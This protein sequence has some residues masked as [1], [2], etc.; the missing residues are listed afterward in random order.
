MKWIALPHSFCDADK[1]VVWIQVISHD[2]KGNMICVGIEFM[3]VY[4]HILIDYISFAYCCICCATFA[5]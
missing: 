2:M 1:K 4:I 3:D 5:Q